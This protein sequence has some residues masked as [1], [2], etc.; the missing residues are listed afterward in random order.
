MYVFAL[1]P[2]DDVTK[3]WTV[4]VAVGKDANGIVIAEAFDVDE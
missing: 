3:I 2:S 4:V 1:E